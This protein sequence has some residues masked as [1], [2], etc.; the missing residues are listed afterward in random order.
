MEGRCVGRHRE[1][2]GSREPRDD[3]RDPVDLSGESNDG[4]LPNLIPIRFGRMMQ[5][6][7]AFCRGS[8]ALTAADLASTP[9]SGLNSASLRRRRS[10]EFWRICHARAQYCVRHQ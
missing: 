2:H 8:A 3:R 10:D 7:F 9:K 6:P 4:R 1:D 5:S